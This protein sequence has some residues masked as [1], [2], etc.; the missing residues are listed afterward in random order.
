MNDV[1]LVSSDGSGGSG[2]GGLGFYAKLTG[3]TGPY[4]WTE[5]TVSGGTITD[6][7]TGVL[8][9][10]EATTGLT[11]IP[12][13]GTVVVW[14][15]AIGDDYFFNAK[16][17]TWV[18]SWTFTGT[19]ETCELVPATTETVVISGANLCGSTT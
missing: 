18:T 5:C 15:I 9:A 13:D 1:P 2:T 17:F 11:G 8:N 4:S 12:V 6:A 14:M 7:L 10:T 3:G 19:G 16:M